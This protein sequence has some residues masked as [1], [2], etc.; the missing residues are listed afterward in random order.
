M[1]KKGNSRVGE[2]EVGI[3]VMITKLYRGEHF[4]EKWEK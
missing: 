1:E 2:G 4:E 3:L